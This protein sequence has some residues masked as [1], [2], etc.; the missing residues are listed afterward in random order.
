MPDNNTL[1]FLIRFGLDKT[2]AEAAAAELGKLKDATNQAGDV[3]VKSSQKS[4][5]ATQEHGKHVAGLHRAVGLLGRQFGHV[6][7]L[8]HFAF[9]SV[10]SV[11]IAAVAIAIGKVIEKFNDWQ[12]QLTDMERDNA[13]ALGPTAAKL[14]EIKDRTIESDVAFKDYQKTVA[15]K[16]EKTLADINAQFEA[17]KKILKAEEAIALAR[18]EDKDQTSEQFRQLEASLGLEEKKQVL[19]ERQI[20]LQEV[21]KKGG[22]KYAQARAALGRTSGE[23]AK[24][25]LET[26]PE[27]IT[28]A[29]NYIARLQEQAKKLP[30]KVY[31]DKPWVTAFGVQLL[32]KLVEV[33]NPE[34]AESD[35]KIEAAKQYK[36]RLQAEKT[37]LITGKTALDESELLGEQMRKKSSEVARLKLGIGA[38]DLA[39]TKQKQAALENRKQFFGAKVDAAE[40]AND[41]SS[42][43]RFS[44][45]MDEIEAQIRRMADIAEAKSKALSVRLNQPSP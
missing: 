21:I 30:A 10:A 43:E 38:E 7:H 16:S 18:S 42:V 12:A 17:L 27:S 37:R 28:G 4:G 29:E 8:A 44:K 3:S 6:G 1:D 32:T 5:E 23:Q 34:V 31:H 9:A 26:I 22:E 35:K 2:Q 14:K 19:A 11:G 39:E 13:E 45:A 15:E 33:D 41:W 36:A 25:A 24:N 20:E 40:Q